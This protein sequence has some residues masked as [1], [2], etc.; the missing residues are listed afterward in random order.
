MKTLKQFHNYIFLIFITVCE[1]QQQGNKAENDPPIS[2]IEDLEKH[3]VLIYVS[4]TYRI[5]VGWRMNL[6]IKSGKFGEARCVS[7][8][9]LWEQKEDIS[10]YIIREPIGDLSSFFEFL[11]DKGADLWKRVQ[12]SPEIYFVLYFPKN[13][14]QTHQ[15]ILLKY[16]FFNKAKVKTI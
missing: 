11:R 2:D 14:W 12:Q 3:G 10:L 9:D 4:D 13:K 5:E 8:L 6:I 7:P 15:T 16:D 1:V